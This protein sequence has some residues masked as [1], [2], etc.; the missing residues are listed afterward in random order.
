MLD[1]EAVR[2]ALAQHPPLTIER[3]T[4]R[5]AAVLLLLF[6]RGGEDHVLLTRRTEHL[7]HH[8]GEISFPGGGRH[9]ED[10]DLRATALRETE[11]EMGIRPT[12]VLLLG[13]LDDILS[14]HDY[15]VT[16]FVGAFSWPYPFRVSAR[17]IA[18][19][20]EV[21]LSAL[22]APGVLRQEDWQ[23][24]GRRQPVLFYTVRGRE[25]WGLTAAILNQFLQRIG[26]LVPQADR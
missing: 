23:H 13:S 15:H 16:P 18:E 24:R 22:T 9:P 14:V 6:T 21:P 11:E 20:I 7:P 25:I 3:G 17:E 26:H 10:V 2:L 19:V 8:R 12:D 5:E 4:L 1:R